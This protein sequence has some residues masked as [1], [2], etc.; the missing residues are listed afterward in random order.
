M[1]RAVAELER[2]L[3][4]GRVP[5]PDIGTSGRLFARGY[6][7]LLNTDGARLKLTF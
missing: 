4:D 5:E 3:R 6:A 7:W 2:S 1:P